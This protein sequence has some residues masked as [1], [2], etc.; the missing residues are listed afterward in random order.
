MA[1]AKQ[2]VR[3]ALM[4]SKEVSV[5]RSF[6]QLEAVKLHAAVMAISNGHHITWN[7]Y[8][9]FGDGPEQK[10]AVIKLTLEAKMVGAVSRESNPISVVTV[11]GGWERC[12]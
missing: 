12:L 8:L 5:L 6:S 11:G 4:T 2:D 3:P 10:Q 1:I 7:D 9:V